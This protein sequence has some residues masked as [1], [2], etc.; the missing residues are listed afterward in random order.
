M[1]ESITTILTVLGWGIGGCIAVFLLVLL[2]LF[3]TGRW[4]IIPTILSIIPQIFRSVFGGFTGL[5]GGADVMS[6]DDEAENVPTR[7]RRQDTPTRA[8]D[9]IRQRREQFNNDPLAPDRRPFQQG[10]QR[11]TL[12]DRYDIR[13]S[14]SIRSGDD[15]HKPSRDNRRREWNEDEIFGG[16]FDEE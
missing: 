1:N 16:M 9:R 10:G 2:V 4:M 7:S 13:P 3:L 11:G 5:F 12:S 14:Q 6:G 15:S 8:S